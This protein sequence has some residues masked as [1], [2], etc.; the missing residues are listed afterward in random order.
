MDSRGTTNAVTEIEL[1]A[2]CVPDDPWGQID[3]SL[4][5]TDPAGRSRRVP[6]FWDGGPT[7]RVR[8]SSPLAGVHSWRSLVR[9][10]AETGLEGKEG[11]I[12]LE[13]YTGS[14]PLLR[15]GPIEVAA[16]GRHLA[17]ADGTPFLWLADTWWSATTA[18]FRW[19]DVFQRLARDRA[20]KGFSVIQLVAGLVPEFP[21]F[22][23]EMA[24]E[25]GQPWLPDAAAGVNPAYWEVPDRKLAHLVQLGIV[26]CVVGAWGYWAAV[27]GRE[28]A[29]RHWRYLIAR[30]AATREPG[31]RIRRFPLPPTRA[32][33]TRCRPATRG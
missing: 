18:R 2:S 14:N 25:G 26:P 24:S 22:S 15:H 21:Q 8:Y 7:W 19:P 3:L 23:A 13:P 17:H 12:A 27:L 11:E 16:D 30:Y 6:A 31:A 33:A 5:F 20:E 32:A 9:G 10:E 28:G 29:E 1:E 4:E